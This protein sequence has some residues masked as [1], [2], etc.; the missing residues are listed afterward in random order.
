[1]GGHQYPPRSG[2]HAGGKLSASVGHAERKQSA[3]ARHVDTVEKTSRS[4]CKLK[5]PCKLCKGDHITHQCPAIAE[6]RRVW[7]ET[8][9]FPSPEKPIVSQQPTQP[10]VD[11][12]VKSISDLV[13]PT[14]LL[15]SVPH[16]I[17]AMSSLVNPTLPS[18]SDFHEA[19]ESISV[20]INPILPLES[21]V[22]ASHIFFTSSSDIT[23][24]IIV[25][26]VVILV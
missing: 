21:E 7:S 25:L 26:H 19:V 15:E 1:M 12:V 6:V 13:D 10:L 24:V 22:S 23:L 8:Q 9:E 3:T 20:S 17:E 2:G 5:F 18:K 4:K 16:V 11:Q 14:L